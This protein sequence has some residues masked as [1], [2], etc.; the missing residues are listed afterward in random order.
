[1]RKKVFK[2]SRAILWNYSRVTK[3]DW[4]WQTVAA[5]LDSVVVLTLAD[6]KKSGPSPCEAGAEF[7]NEAAT[8][9][10]GWLGTGP[11]RRRDCQWVGGVGRVSEDTAVVL[12]QPSPGAADRS[13]R[14]PGLPTNFHIS[15]DS[16]NRK[17]WKDVFK[18]FQR[19]YPQIRGSPQTNTL[20]ASLKNE[21]SS[22]VSIK[23]L[24]T[25]KQIFVKDHMY[26]HNQH[27]EKIWIIF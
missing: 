18:S 2:A 20:K 27:P 10:W 7:W 9:N 8:A 19:H 4:R 26:H 14:S 1:M 21:S 3:D 23:C 16:H 11:R 6:S 22:L 25:S 12:R 5:M 24:H 13:C 15:T 17:S